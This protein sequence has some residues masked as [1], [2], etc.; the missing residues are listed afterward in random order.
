MVRWT[1]LQRGK[2]KPIE[3]QGVT[4]NC[5]AA[6]KG[7]NSLSSKCQAT[8]GIFSGST[9]I[10]KIKRRFQGRVLCYL[11]GL[12]LSGDTRCIM[13]W[14]LSLAWIVCAPTFGTA[15]TVAYYITAT[16]WPIKN[17][18]LK[19]QILFTCF[20]FLVFPIIH[21]IKY[22]FFNPARFYLSHPSPARAH[23]V[24][25]LVSNYPKCTPLILDNSHPSSSSNLRYS[26]PVKIFPYL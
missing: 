26:F 11:W 22:I 4:K 18:R 10:I 14:R 1:E 13:S 9:R 25:P 12:N 21:R 5:C 3:N 20:K 19:V 6:E 23:T 2:W 15:S 16:F 7:S 17:D 24:L 8:C